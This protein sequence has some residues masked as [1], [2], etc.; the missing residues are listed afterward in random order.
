MAQVQEIMLARLQRPLRF[1]ELDLVARRIHLTEAINFTAGTSQVLPCD[2]AVLAELIR[3]CRAMCDVVDEFKLPR[4]H[5][6]LE[7]HVHKTKDLAKCE[8]LSWE[9]PQVISRRIAAG[10]TPESILHAIGYGWCSS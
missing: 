2:M 10:G 9:R 5:L 6:R 8:R 1:I 3:A 7:G 4:I